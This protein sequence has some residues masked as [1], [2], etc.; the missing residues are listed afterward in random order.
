MNALGYI[1]F[2]LLSVLGFF[3]VALLVINHV[4]LFN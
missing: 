1:F 3:A 2:G 4:I